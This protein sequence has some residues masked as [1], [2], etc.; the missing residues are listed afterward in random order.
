M[1]QLILK[2]AIDLEASDIHIK[3]GA[4]PVY[5]I[6]K[7]LHVDE[8]FPIITEEHFGLFL[9]EVVGKNERKSKEF[10][11]LGE[12]DLSYSLPKVSR[13]RVN[14]YKQRGTSGMAFRVIPFQIPPFKSL[15][16]P[17]VM[18]KTALSHTK[19]LILVTGPTGSGKSTTLASIIEEINK[20]FKRVI[21]TIEDPIEYVLNDRNCFI[22]Q[23]EVG[24]DTQSFARGLRAALR[25]DPDVIM[26]GEIR[27]TETAEI[28]L[29][30]A[31]T[32]H[33]VFSTLHT[34]DAKETVNRL[35][36]MF[37]LEVRDQIR[38]MLAGTLIA[39]FSQRLLPRA[40]RKGSI[41]AVEVM[42]NTGAI[43]EALLDPN[44]I[45]EIPDLV[46]KG[47]A[48]Y[49]T[50]TFDQHLEEL[51]RKG[52]IDFHTAVLYATKPSDLE[53]KLRGIS[54]GAEF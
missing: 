53:L 13:F 39:V 19:G 10:E 6:H 21:V 42:L 41:P 18:L 14:V 54:S 16:L 2:K 11:E 47:K 17:E 40:D 30:A 24:I 15:N 28:A 26:V 27:D 7:K 37:K 23:R 52:L 36:G 34:L 46:A 12:I 45:D 49:G 1:L 51:Y 5:R 31:E 38:Q 50:Q 4:K 32:G 29:Q 8:D 35:I 9:K 33:L 22:V 43:K 48:A 3:V 20:N 25:E 44:R